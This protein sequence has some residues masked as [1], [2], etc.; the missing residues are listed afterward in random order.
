MSNHW[1]FTVDKTTSRTQTIKSTAMLNYVHAPVPLYVS[2][3]A[4]HTNLF[5]SAILLHFLQSKISSQILCLLIYK[6]TTLLAV[7][8]CTDE[9][10][11]QLNNVSVLTWVCL[12]E[13]VGKYSGGIKGEQRMEVKTPCVCDNMINRKWKNS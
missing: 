3:S 7:M 9:Q 2:F 8:S 13:P 10:W 4:S 11:T 5:I 12:Q 1:A 6:S